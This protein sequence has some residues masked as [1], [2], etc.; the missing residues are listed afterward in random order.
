MITDARVERYLLGLHA[1]DDA[2]IRAMQ[3]E[4]E[5]RGFPIIGPLVG[6][7]C[8]ILARCIGARRVFEMGS[9]FGYSTWWFARAVGDGG[10]VVHTDADARLTAEASQWLSQAGLAGRVRFETGDALDILRAVRPSGGGP[11]DVV[12]IDVDKGDYPECWRL[13]RDRVRRGGLIIADN[14]LWQGKV[15]DGRVRDEWTQA[16]REYA[17]L[18][19]ADDAF[20]TRIVPLRDGV[21]VS[22]R[23][24]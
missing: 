7:L 6:G 5:K 24:R 20:L 18:A 4:G 21:A 1:P 8:E 17:R 11:F 10:E 23:V 2:V 15:A 14:T 19:T 12:F 22:L 13:A 16:V 3:V 9:G